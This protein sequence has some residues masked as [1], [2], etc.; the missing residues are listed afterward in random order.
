MSSTYTDPR[1]DSHGI[2]VTQSQPVGALIIGGDHPGLGVARSLGRRGIPVYVMDD[3]HCISAY[4]KYVRRVIRTR[5]LRGDRATTDAVLETG[6]RFNLRN[7][8]L[9][10][11]RDETVAAF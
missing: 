7:W 4:S 5:D 3:Q 9:F 10:P 2:A 11:T 1:Q 6:H 8:V